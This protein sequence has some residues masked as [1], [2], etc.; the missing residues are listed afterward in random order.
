MPVPDEFISRTCF[1]GYVFD[2]NLECVAVEFIR[3]G[4]CDDGT[5]IDPSTHRPIDRGTGRWVDGSI[6]GIMPD[7]SCANF[8]YDFGDC[9][10]LS[11]GG[12]EPS[13]E[14][15]EP[16]VEDCAGN[17][18]PIASV[19][20]STCDDGSS[21]DFN[22]ASFLYDMLDCELPV[23]A[24]IEA[25]LGYAGDPEILNATSPAYAA[26]ETSFTV[27]ISTAL[28]VQPEEVIIT[29]V[30]ASGSGRRRMQ[31]L[32]VEVHFNVQAE[33][34]S[35]SMGLADELR[36]QAADPTSPL[37]TSPTLAAAVDWDAGVSAAP[38]VE[39][40][41]VEVQWAA[42]LH[43]VNTAQSCEGVLVFVAVGYQQTVDWTLT[44]FELQTVS[45]SGTAE[46][47]SH[48][49]IT[50][51][52]R[53]CVPAG[54]YVLEIV[55]VGNG[56]TVTEAGDCCTGRYGVTLNDGGA[57]VAS[58]TDFP[59]SVEAVFGLGVSHNTT[60]IS[61]ARACT[62]QNLWTYD[63]QLFGNGMCASH[64]SIAG[65]TWCKTTDPACGMSGCDAGNGMFGCD[66]FS[67]DYCAHEQSV[68]RHVTPNEAAVIGNVESSGYVDY[69][70]FDAYA[71]LSY[72]IATSLGTLSDSY[73]ILYGTD[74]ITVLQENDDYGGL[75]S[76]IP[77]FQ[78]SETGTYVVAV[79][80][81]SPSQTG[82]F[83]A[84]ITFVEPE[85]P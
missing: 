30:E 9:H 67:F 72:D 49:A 34:A 85:D 1:P 23:V 27:E 4:T 39:A 16:S 19:G 33:N 59:S 45:A 13:V 71:G 17:C 7:F 14:G 22:C 77:A 44:H 64:T 18:N 8:Y 11:C 52:E 82:T 48:S 70:V 81:Y 78:C 10:I 38:V 65:L 53:F 50:A 62:C 61:T 26:F 42:D 40:S 25:T 28:S 69:F 84:E 12:C 66:D 83:M 21:A 75:Q 20:D 6:T 68:F 31:A 55:G 24:Y 79:R 41:V 5:G 73:M 46:A 56:A 54:T 36:A 60:R 57:T 43:E 47:G 51:G 76:R 80:G 35:A 29:G 74:G 3:D 63:S 37:R 2:C 15:C 32:A 58:G